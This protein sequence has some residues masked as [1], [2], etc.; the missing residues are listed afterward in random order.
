MTKDNDNREL[1]N[2]WLTS[3]A[4]RSAS[5]LTGPEP[6]IIVVIM[7]LGGMWIQ[8]QL[9]KDLREAEVR[10][11]YIAGLEKLNQEF[12]L[13][14]RPFAERFLRQNE[15]D[16]EFRELLIQNLQKQS[17]TL[18]DMRKLAQTEEQRKALDS[19][20][21]SIS[22]MFKLVNTASERSEIPLHA[23][24]YAQLIDAKARFV[25]ELRDS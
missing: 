1:S 11:T 9:A 16:G 14:Y 22:R 7:G 12:Q 17:A 5:F 6:W 24:A 21:E 8:H 25:D 4:K 18:I 3:W 23:E 10:Q 15:I 19:Y 2:G 20:Q 13:E